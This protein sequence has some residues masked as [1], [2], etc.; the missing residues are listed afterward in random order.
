MGAQQNADPLGNQ[1]PVGPARVQLAQL[2]KG[3]REASNR[4]QSWVAK[5]LH[6][7]QP[8]VSRWE[9]G[10][11]LPAPETIR[12]FWQICAKPAKSAVSAPE[13]DQALTFHQRAMEERA[14]VPK[15]TPPATGETPLPEQPS[16]QPPNRK[17]QL[18][19]LTAVGVVALLAAAAWAG[20]QYSNSAP[21]NTASSPAPSMAAAR[22]TPTAACDSDACASLEPATTA[23]AQDATTVQTGHGYGIRVE[24]RYSTLCRAAWAKMSGT[25]AGDRVMITPKQGNA[26]EY[27]QQYGHDAHTRMVAALTPG[28]AQ[29]CAIVEGRGTVCATSS[30]QQ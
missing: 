18:V 25:A 29:A 8:T 30:A 10:S 14:H 4:S 2:L 26:Q 1:Q 9:S 19:A 27:R 24:L 28:D 11:T 20:V 6:T 7:N 16:P 12:A 23:C 3:W 21:E 5:Q 15:Q 22:S 17:G 13:L